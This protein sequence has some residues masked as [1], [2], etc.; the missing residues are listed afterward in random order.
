MIEV[1]KIFVDANSQ[2]TRTREV[3]RPIL[4]TDNGFSRSINTSV[5][6][7]NLYNY[8]NYTIVFVVTEEPFCSNSHAV[9]LFSAS[10]NG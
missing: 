1:K 3:Q 5:C 6:G 10:N 2:T 9:R 7:D 4:M 8:E